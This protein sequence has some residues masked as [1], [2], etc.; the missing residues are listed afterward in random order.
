MFSVNVSIT[1][2]NLIDFTCICNNKKV[3]CIDYWLMFPGPCLHLWTRQNGWHYSDDISNAS[4]RMHIFLLW[5]GFHRTLFLIIQM[6]VGRY[7]F[8]SWLFKYIFA[9]ALIRF[10]IKISQNFI[11]R[12]PSGNREALVW[13]IYNHRSVNKPL[14]EPIFDSVMFGGCALWI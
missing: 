9:N 4:S 7:W 11:S 12:S 2:I 5:S 6:G 3:I 14:S 10:F 1:N 8:G 13:V